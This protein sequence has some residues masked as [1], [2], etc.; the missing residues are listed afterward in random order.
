MRQDGGEAEFL[1]E[2]GEQETGCEQEGGGEASVLRGCEG[3]EVGGTEEGV[4]FVEEGYG[5]ERSSVS[6]KGRG[7]GA[8]TVEDCG[9]AYRC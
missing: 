9:W 8:W 2:G 4:D 6:V 1:P 3:W 7:R 5:E